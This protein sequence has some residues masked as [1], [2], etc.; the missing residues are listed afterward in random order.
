MKIPLSYRPGYE[1]A[2]SFDPSLADIY[3]SNTMVGDPLADAAIA[4]LAD[5][6]HA[7]RHELING[8]MERDKNLMSSAPTEL[9]DF[10]HALDAPPPRPVV[11]DPEI[12]I[13]GSRAFYKY[14][15]MFFVGLVLDSLITGLTEGLSK[16]FF[17]TGRTA[18][19]LRRVRQ[20]TRHVA[21]V[22][23]PGGLERMGD[24]WKLT[25]RIRLIHAQVRRLLLDSDEWDVAVEGVPVH[26][27]HMA[28]AATGFSAANLAA[29]EKLGVV[30]TAE[31]KAGFMHIWRYVTWLLGVPETLLFETEEQAER[32]RTI[33]RLV[34]REPGEMAVGVAHGYINTV[35]EILSVTEPKKQERL[36]K[37]LLRTSRALI[38]NELADQLAF[39]KQSTFGALAFVRLERRL[40]I[41]ASKILP[42]KNS[43]DLDNFT[44]LMQRSVYDDIGFSYRMPDAIKDTDATPW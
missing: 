42:W 11:F 34:E 2:R 21:E 18:G 8:C 37:L 4:S 16:A 43:H 44:G 3:V 9:R 38:G 29:V 23:L 7:K 19:N 5:L 28:L 14:S 30:L 17:I 27:S 20:N 10:F 35:P 1:K 24:G 15:D 25:V 31:E 6:D 22:T 26:M 41:I 40:K 13:A 36:I 33:S 12:A 39:P 32:L